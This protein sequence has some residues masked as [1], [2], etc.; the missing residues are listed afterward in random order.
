MLCFALFWSALYCILLW[1]GSAPCR[2]LCAA[3]CTSSEKARLSPL[4]ACVV[5]QVKEVLRSCPHHAVHSIAEER[6]VCGSTYQARSNPHVNY[7]TYGSTQLAKWC[8][9]A[10]LRSTYRPHR[11][12]I[13]NIQ[14]CNSLTHC[15]LLSDLL[16]RHEFLSPRN[17][18]RFGH[19]CYSSGPYHDRWRSKARTAW[20][21]I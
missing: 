19:M 12:H 17:P 1:S 11:N 10:V 21:L 5:L 2:M 4:L 7:W 14:Q 13:Y 15:A 9:C 16:F 8:P 18:H 3:M 20:S 6:S